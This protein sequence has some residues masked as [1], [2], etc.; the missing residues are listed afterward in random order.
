MSSR[1]EEF[2]NCLVFSPDQVLFPDIS[3]ASFAYPGDEEALAALE[4][5]PGA[6]G[7]LSYLQR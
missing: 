1:A 5:I 3:Y 7:V 4:H 6:P 2:A